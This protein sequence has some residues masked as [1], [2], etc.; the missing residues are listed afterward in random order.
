LVHSVLTQAS[1][2]EAQWLSLAVILVLAFG[3]VA[4]SAVYCFI[5]WLGVTRFTPMGAALVAYEVLVAGIMAVKIIV[6][7]TQHTWSTGGIVVTIVA[8]CVLAFVVFIDWSSRYF[9]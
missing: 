4:A 6:S 1:G 3:V 9:D 7:S 5:D 8:G 2:S